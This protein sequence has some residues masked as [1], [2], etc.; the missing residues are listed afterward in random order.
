[1]EEGRG[2]SEGWNGI[3]EDSG[4]AGAGPEVARLSHGCGNRGSGVEQCSGEAGGGRRWKGDHFA[5]IEKFKGL[6]VN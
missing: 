5:N 4:R 6:A 2:A 3:Q 1:M